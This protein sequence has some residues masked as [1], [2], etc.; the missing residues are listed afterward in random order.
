[1]KKASVKGQKKSGAVAAQ[2]A[3][4]NGIRHRHFFLANAYGATFWDCLHGN[5]CLRLAQFANLA[6]R[7]LF[8]RRFFKARG[9]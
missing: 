1:M 9:E 6:D 5:M 2:K 3:A 8:L 7:R 4:N